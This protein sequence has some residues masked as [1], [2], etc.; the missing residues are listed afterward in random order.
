M[1]RLSGWLCDLWHGPLPVFGVYVALAIYAL[2]FVG[3]AFF[4][5]RCLICSAYAP[6]GYESRW[7]PASG[8]QVAKELEW[9]AAAP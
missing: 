7:T 5:S 9:K 8:C 6:S 1:K 4:V 3:I 2:F